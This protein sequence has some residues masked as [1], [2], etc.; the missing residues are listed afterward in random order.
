MEAAANVHF[1]HSASTDVADSSKPA[2]LV[3]RLR[4]ELNREQK[5]R[6]SL[7]HL[8]NMERS[9]ASGGVQQAPPSGKVHV[10]LDAQSRSFLERQT[11]SI[12]AMVDD[13][14]SGFQRQLAAQSAF[15]KGSQAAMAVDRIKSRSSRTETPMADA[16]D[17]NTSATTSQAPT[18]KTDSE[19]HSFQTYSS[20]FEDASQD[21][22]QVRST[23]ASSVPS[24]ANAA[25]AKQNKDRPFQ[26]NLEAKNASR[27]TKEDRSRRRKPPPRAAAAADTSQPTD[28]E[29]SLVSESKSELDPLDVSNDGDSSILAPKAVDLLV[30]EEAKQQRL[31]LKLREKATVERT[32]AELELL[33]MQKRILR[34][35]GEREKA[36]SIKKKQRG[37]LLKLQDER[38]K[39]EAM[40]KVHRR[41]VDRRMEQ[42]ANQ[43]ANQ[44]TAYESSSWET[45]WSAPSADSNRL[46]ADAMRADKDHSS[47]T[48]MAAAESDKD[49]SASA[50]PV[51]QAVQ[52]CLTSHKHWPH[53]IVIGII[54]RIDST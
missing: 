27:A 1:V 19:L 6:N 49:S 9:A 33:Q 46:S 53:F 4:S 16:D 41:Q 42:M 31:L 20:D 40:R 47:H 32:L 22:S 11:A 45:D 10:K 24:E 38:A 2:E 52:V 28:A 30:L 15:V 7:H 43:A 14:G 50:Q 51:S 3:A 29:Q 13:L 44:S 21:R 37:L 26:F 34:A 8:S 12:R 54:S 48:L 36:A 25:P 18:V 5:L 17:A 39:I 35:Q 23:A